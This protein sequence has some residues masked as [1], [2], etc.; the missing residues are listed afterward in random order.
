MQN[1]FHALLNDEIRI[2]V[3]ALCA[4][5]A[6][7]VL[8]N[9][10]F[11]I[12]IRLRRQLQIA[13]K[14]IA[15]SDEGYWVINALGHFVEVNDGYCRMTGFTRDQIMGM[16]I[17]DFEEVATL[18]RIQAQ[19]RRILDKGYERFETRHRCADGAWVELEISVTSVDRRYLV[20]F[21]RNITQRKQLEATARSA[22]DELVVYRRDLERL[23]ADRTRE[24]AEAQQRAEQASLAKTVFLANMSHEIRTPLNAVLGIAHVM[25]RVEHSPQ[26][27]EHLARI[28]HAGKHLLSIVNNILDI[29]KIEAGKMTL[30][31]SNF[32]LR[33]VFD[34]VRDIVEPLAREKGIA[35]SVECDRVPTMLCGDAVRLRQSLLNFASNAVKFTE[36][37]SITMRAMPIGMSYSPLTVRFEVSDTGL[38]IAPADRGRVFNAF[39]QADKST[40]RRFGGTGLGLAITRNLARLMGGDVGVESEPGR[41]S[42]FWFTANL[43]QA[44]DERSAGD[45]L[46]AE[47]AQA[48]QRLLET[49]KGA[50]VLL[51]DDSAVNREV[52]FYL[53]DAVGLVVEMAANGHIAVEMA[54]EFEYDLILMDMQMPRMNGL[55]ATRIIRTMPPW[56]GRAR[57]IVAMTANVFAEDRLACEEAGMNDFIAKPLVPETFYATLLRWL[58]DT[59]Q[60]DALREQA[61]RDAGAGREPTWRTATGAS[62]EE[63]ARLAGL[64]GLNLEFGLKVFSG[65]ADR[66]LAMLER[67]NVVHSQEMRALEQALHDGDRQSGLALGHSIKGAANMLGLDEIAASVLELEK[68]LPADDGTVGE[69]A[70]MRQQ[71]ETAW[72]AFGALEQMLHDSLSADRQTT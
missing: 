41:G 12:M 9:I 37:G 25:R 60:R 18:E 33:D 46:Q 19:I 52:A 39:E 62:G 38:G 35:V 48:E 34:D 32:S 1:I 65:Q 51:V 22:N 3:M 42:T 68:H 50:R 30:E 14:A 5:L 63:L 40:T 15:S 10:I 56:L 23:V 24:L 16:T 20:A 53:L 58:P 69:P 11:V 13:G 36:S 67:F 49:C 59:A 45:I 27:A 7:F 61:V 47:L 31:S 43:M 57:P 66:Y 44:S 8:A 2:N 29:S 17:A 26:Q 55:D 71:I 64:P 4:G 72:Q 21:L 54:S 70:S 28:D 6:S